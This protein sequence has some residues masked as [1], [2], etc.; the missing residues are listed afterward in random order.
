MNS[1]AR[2]AQFDLWYPTR[3]DRPKGWWQV[4]GDW[5][6]GRRG[7]V[8]ARIVDVGGS[9]AGIE[10]L[11]VRPAGD[12]KVGR[13]FLVRRDFCP[14]DQLHMRES[15]N[16]ELAAQAGLG[17]FVSPLRLALLR[18]GRTPVTVLS[19]EWA[20]EVLPAPDR[21]MWFASKGRSAGW[22]H[23]LPAENEY[24]KRLRALGLST[25]GRSGR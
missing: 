2:Y 18:Q 23:L 10:L 20:R 19:P 15:R 8:L 21:A 4:A 5:D 13:P 6:A 3:S 9:R 12:L 24:C 16:Q 11:G 22:R 7:A 14:W 17:A 25:A 1:N